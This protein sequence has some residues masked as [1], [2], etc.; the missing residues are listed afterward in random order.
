MQDDQSG[1]RRKVRLERSDLV[2]K[3][4][5]LRSDRAREMLRRN[6]TMLFLE[7]EEMPYDPRAV[8]VLNEKGETLGYLPRDLAARV[9]DGVRSALE[10]GEEVPASLTGVTDE[11]EVEIDLDLENFL[12]HESQL[13]ATSRDKTAG[14]KNPGL[15]AMIAIIAFYL[16]YRMFTRQG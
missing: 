9:W 15:Y 3:N 11:G 2:E 13:L 10:E 16:A 4:G 6:E 14:K 5:S 12:G 1:R 8:V 7:D